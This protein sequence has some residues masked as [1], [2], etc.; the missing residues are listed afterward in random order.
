MTAEAVDSDPYAGAF[1]VVSSAASAVSLPHTCLAFTLSYKFAL[2]SAE[3]SVALTVT[4]A[5]PEV[6]SIALALLVRP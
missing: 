4:G 3:L 2:A 6:L 1:A 5:N